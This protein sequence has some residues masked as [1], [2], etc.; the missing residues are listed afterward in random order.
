MNLVLASTSIYRK[1]LLSRLKIPF[2]ALKPLAD[3]D[4]LKGQW[5]NPLERAQNLARCKAESL[6][7]ASS[8]VIG[9]DQLAQLEGRILEKPHGFDKALE[10][11]TFMAG[12]THEL[13]TAVH[14]CQ[15][16]DTFYS[17]TDITRLTMKP[18]TEDQIKS[19]LLKEEPYDCAGSYKIEKLGITLF[20]KIETQDFTAITGLPLIELS[21][22]LTKMGFNIP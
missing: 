7:K 6:K 5:T 12:K 22:Q 11:L 14:I 2:N 1:E 8:V 19:Y 20:D 16:E 15:N 13:I 17:F 18:L 21:K 3:E 4:A 10:Q 9:S